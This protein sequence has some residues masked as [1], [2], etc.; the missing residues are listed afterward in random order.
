[1]ISEELTPS[2]LSFEERGE[3]GLGD[4]FIPW[5]YTQ[6]YKHVVSVGLQEKVCWWGI[7]LL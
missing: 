6:G 3:R 7:V 5:V 1:V 2:P 4:F